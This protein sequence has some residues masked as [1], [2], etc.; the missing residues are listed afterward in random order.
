VGGTPLADCTVMAAAHFFEFEVLQTN[1]IVRR[2]L[3]HR[4]QQFQVLKSAQN[5]HFNLLWAVAP[6]WMSRITRLADV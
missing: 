2:G 3:L 6:N 4:T 1:I 5:G